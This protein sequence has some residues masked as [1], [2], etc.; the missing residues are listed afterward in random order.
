MKKKNL[1]E[2][3]RQERE[4]F[5]KCF[6]E[7]VASLDDEQLDAFMT[8]ACRVADD[9]KMQKAS[10]EEK[11]HINFDKALDDEHRGCKSLAVYVLK[12]YHKVRYL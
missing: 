7:A 2:E 5:N 3:K 6:I 8:F 12:K 1:E 10:E 11:I 4:I 9:I